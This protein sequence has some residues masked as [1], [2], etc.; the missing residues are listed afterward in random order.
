ML[1]SRFIPRLADRVG[2]GEAFHDDGANAE[3]GEDPARHEA[4]DAPAE[5][6]DDGGAGGLVSVYGAL[7]ALHELLDD[8]A[9]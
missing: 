6:H 9:R 8:A 4:G 1:S 2:V 5:I 3:P 7:Q